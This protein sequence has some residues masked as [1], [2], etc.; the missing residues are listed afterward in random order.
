MAPRVD[1]RLVRFG[2]DS[3]DETGYSLENRIRKGEMGV[4]EDRSMVGSDGEGR[5]RKVRKE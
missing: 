2:D 4:R 5:V 3:H 1:H